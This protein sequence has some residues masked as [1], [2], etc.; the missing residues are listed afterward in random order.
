MGKHDDPG[1]TFGKR[2][3][4]GQQARQPRC[5]GDLAIANWNVEIG[6]DK[7]P[8]AGNVGAVDGLE[9][10]ELHDALVFRLD[11][12]LALAAVGFACSRND[13]IDCQ[14]EMF[15]QLVGWRGGSEVAK[16]D[17]SIAG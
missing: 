10:V 1:A 12:N 15:E 14:T 5:I 17:K 16:T 9:I 7:H 6:A 13:R 8:L 11:W 2:Q 4:A 3:K